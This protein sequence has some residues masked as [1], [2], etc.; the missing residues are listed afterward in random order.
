MVPSA[1]VVLAALPVG[2][3]GKVDRAALPEPA[4]RSAAARI[5][6]KTELERQLLAVWEAVL[7]R[8]DLGT[9]D[10]FF[11]VGGDSI[12]SLQIVARART[13]GIRVTPKQI[14][15]QPTV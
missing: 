13:L 15:E 2:G 14:F 4:L 7:A 9:T 12:M 3:A 6:P 10:N 1:I 8:H 5:A 11:D